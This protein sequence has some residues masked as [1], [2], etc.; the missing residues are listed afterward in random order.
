MSEYY[1]V[2]CVSEEAHSWRA[3]VRKHAQACAAN[4]CQS[5][6]WVQVSPT[7][8]FILSSIFCGQIIL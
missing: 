6:M 4:K 8:K 1:D 7:P 5:E 3:K 2:H